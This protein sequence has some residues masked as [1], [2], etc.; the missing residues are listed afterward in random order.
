MP[1]FQLYYDMIIKRLDIGLSVGKWRFIYLAISHR[2]IVYCA[3]IHLDT[4]CYCVLLCHHALA[5]YRWHQL[6]VDRLLLMTSYSINAQNRNG[7]IHE[8]INIVLRVTMAV[9][10][11]VNYFPNVMSTPIKLI[12]KLDA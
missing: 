10:V 8:H 3:K 12:S 2:I 1:L 11:T 7:P 9:T 5:R 6:S 4:C